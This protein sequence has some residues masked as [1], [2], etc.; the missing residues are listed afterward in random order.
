MTDSEVQET[1]NAPAQGEPM[2]FTGR[3]GP[4]AKILA[5]NAVFTLL[6]FGIYRF[7]AK[8]WVRRYFW[9]NTLIR[10]EPMEYTG[11]PMELFIGFLVVMV[12]IVPI[13]LLGGLAEVVSV[14]A[15][16]L[17]AVIYNVFYL[18]LLFALIQVAFYRMWRYRLTRTTWRGVR[19]GLDGST[20]KFMGKALVWS[21]V[22]IFTLGL[23]APWMRMALIR[24]RL[25]N[26]RFGNT[27]FEFKGSGAPLFP[28]WMVVFVSAGLPLA[29]IAGLVG[30]AEHANPNDPEA[31]AN[32]V[33]TF[34]LFAAMIAAVAPFMAMIWY[35]VREFRYVMSKLTFGEA[36]FSSGLSTRSILLA[37]LVTA[38][39]FLAIIFVIGLLFGALGYAFTGDDFNDPGVF[40]GLIGFG[41]AVAVL[42]QWI[43]GPVIV[44][45]FFR[46]AIISKVAETLEIAN[47][48]AFDHVAQSPD[49]G[50]ERGEGLADALDVGAV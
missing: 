27:T 12:A 36:A 34:L 37:G 11:T 18:L 31:P 15:G 35:R 44:G 21:G 30:A 2:A 6:T 45:V 43:V 41:I 8:T 9:S 50:P 19:F 49:K 29:M 33:A 14:A 38:G 23:G 22:A 39:V 1:E 13:S 20:W 10:G 47:V 17:G 24:Y 16:E 7:W 26:T 3:K 40:Q 48:E 4:L 32:A 42:A 28:A 46:H 5:K 25:E